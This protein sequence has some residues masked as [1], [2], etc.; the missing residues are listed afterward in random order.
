[1]PF[2]NNPA[3]GKNNRGL[4]RKEVTDGT[5]QR[6]A[7]LCAAKHLQLIGHAIGDMANHL[8]IG[9]FKDAWTD[10][11]TA[12]PRLEHA[13]HLLPADIPEIGQLG[14][15]TSMQPYHKADDGRYAESYIGS[16]RSK[17][18]YAYKD[19]LDSGGI[20]AFGSDWP[21]VTINPFLGMESAVTGKTLAGTYWQTQNDI[22]VYEA[23]RAYTSSGAYAMFW[24]DRIGRIA[25]GYLA[26]F[27]ILSDSPFGPEPNWAGMHPIATY[28]GGKKV[29]GD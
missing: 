21:V 28:V 22:T 16:E 8:L 12:R 18:S 26:D 25:P 7:A 11:R 29:Y 2:L 14:I 20:L 6:I 15:V 3:D 17:T 5:I 23:L 24:E 9:F 10:V 1:E 13:Q 27:V 4:P 19:I